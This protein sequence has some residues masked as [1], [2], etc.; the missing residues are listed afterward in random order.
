MS[1]R[2]KFKRDAVHFIP[3]NNDGSREGFIALRLIIIEF[4]GFRFEFFERFRFLAGDEP[5]NG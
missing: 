3:Q 4:V 5:D 1:K 2:G